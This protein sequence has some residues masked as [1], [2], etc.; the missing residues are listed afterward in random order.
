MYVPNNRSSNYMRQKLLKLQEEM[1][2]S[3]IMVG[4]FNTSLS[5]MDKYSRQKISK[6]IVEPNNSINQL[7]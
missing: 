5:E 1:D 3:T 4:D 2:K 7:I 6:D